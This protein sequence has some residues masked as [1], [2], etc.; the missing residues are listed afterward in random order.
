MIKFVSN[1]IRGATFQRFHSVASLLAVSEADLA[2]SPPN[3]MSSEPEKIRLD[4]GAPHFQRRAI[5][6]LLKII[7]LADMHDH[8][9]SQ[10]YRLKIAMPF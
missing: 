10:P 5:T 4:L 6:L 3:W 2:S 7:L 9:R 8:P 1:K